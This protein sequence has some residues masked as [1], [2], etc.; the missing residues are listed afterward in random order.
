MSTT[1]ARFPLRYSR[2]NAVLM[3]LLGMGRRRSWV[4]VEP[5]VVRIRMGVAFR[6]SIPRPS[7]VEAGRERRYVWWGY[8]VHWLGV[9]GR[10]LVNGSGRGIVKIRIDPPARARVL[11]VPLRL[12]EV[13]VSL[14]DP[15]GFLAALSR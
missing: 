6:T 9:G 11:G 7:I 2:F 13:W 5:D 4:D 14:E 15:D 3:G 1:A 10:W 12:G 8:G